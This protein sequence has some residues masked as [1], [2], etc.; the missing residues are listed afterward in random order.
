MSTPPNPSRAEGDDRTIPP[1]EE[2]TPGQR[3]DEL[4]SHGLLSFLHSDDRARQTARVE[5][6][7]EALRHET[8]QVAPPAPTLKFPMKAIRAWAALAAAMGII[9]A[10]AV[11]GMPRE[12]SASAAVRDSIEALRGPG[13]RRFEVYITTWQDDQSS[14]RTTPHAIVDTRPPS[15]MLIR[16]ERPPLMKGNRGGPAD[17]RSTTIVGRD[18]KGRWAIRMDGAIERDNPEI[19]WPRFAAMENQSLFAESVDAMLD[20]MSRVY[21]FD[22]K[23]DEALE[24]RPDG[25]FRRIDGV[26][27]RQVGPGPSEMSVWIDPTTKLVERLELRW[28]EEDRKRFGGP[29]GPRP[30]GGPPGMDR[31]DRPRPDGERPPRHGRGPHP[32]RDG[33]KDRD[34]DGP[35]GRRPDNDRDMDGPGPGEGPDG[36]PRGPDDVRDEAPGQG[37][38]VPPPDDRRDGGP[39]EGGRPPRGP[40]MMGGPRGGGEGPMMRPPPPRRIVIQR[41]EAPNFEDSWFS[42]ET[43]LK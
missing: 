8:E 35:R 26:R 11:L 40:M 38:G 22:R 27:K 20:E 39:R 18:A 9:T 3:A 15:Q 33:D 12:S 28:N 29:D 1:A 5:R 36:P 10:V 41:V 17:D 31:G 16:A 6:V 19:A 37:D 21:Q 2:G 34:M 13:D 32:G 43:H 4:L 7:I 23:G 14:P 25:K 42:P 30:M 24:G